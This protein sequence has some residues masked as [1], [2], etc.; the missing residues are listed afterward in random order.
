MMVP[1]TNVPVTYG[2]FA[3]GVPCNWRIRAADK[4]RRHAE[5]EQPAAVANLLPLSNA[6]CADVQVGFEGG[7]TKKFAMGGLWL[8]AR[9]NKP[10]ANGDTWFAA[11]SFEPAD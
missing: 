10:T 5:L 4:P 11:V 1:S 2:P 8:I 6:V 3:F 7:A 9:L